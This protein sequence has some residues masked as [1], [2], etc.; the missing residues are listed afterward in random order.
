MI[1]CI[2]TCDHSFFEPT[3]FDSWLQLG[4]SQNQTAKVKI[5]FLISANDNHLLIFRMNRT[6]NKLFFVRILLFFSE[7]SSSCQISKVLLHLQLDNWKLKRKK[8]AL[9]LLNI[10]F[11]WVQSPNIVSTDVLSKYEQ[12]LRTFRTNYVMSCTALL[13]QT[14]LSNLSSNWNLKDYFESYRLRFLSEPSIVLL[15]LNPWRS[16][17]RWIHYETLLEN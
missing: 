17:Y 2:N 14:L 11:L 4:R 13:L 6:V 16:L 5:R 3:T 7:T 10:I 15:I 9:S 8:L 12:L 1:T